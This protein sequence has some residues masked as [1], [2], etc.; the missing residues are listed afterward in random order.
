MLQKVGTP[1]VAFGEKKLTYY[2]FSSLGVAA[3]RSGRAFCSY[4]FKALH[5]TAGIH[6]NR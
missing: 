2:K 4:A 1:L 3:D 5:T 6:A